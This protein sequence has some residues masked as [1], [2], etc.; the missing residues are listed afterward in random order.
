MEYFFWV[1][2]LLL[3]CWICAEHY[4]LLCYVYEEL[5][6]PNFDVRESVLAVKT[7]LELEFE[8][9]D[10]TCDFFLFLVEF[11]CTEIFKF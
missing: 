8:P 6:G 9:I 10:G 5:A 3:L 7:M 2:D 1:L 4:D 11:I